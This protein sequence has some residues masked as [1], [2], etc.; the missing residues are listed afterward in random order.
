MTYES[1]NVSEAALRAL[2]DCAAQRCDPCYLFKSAPQT[3]AG[4]TAVGVEI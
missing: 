2:Q 4:L 1:A 3:T